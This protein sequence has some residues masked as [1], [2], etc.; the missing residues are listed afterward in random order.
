MTLE[1]TCGE[2]ADTKAINASYLIMD[3]LSPYSIILGQPTIN[4]IRTIISTQYLGLKYM[5]PGGK[6][7]MIRGDQ[8]ITQECYKNSL[9]TKR[10]ELTLVGA[11]SMKSQI[12]TSIF[13][14]PGRV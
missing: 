5:I 6:V 1:I 7:G 11:P 13:G 3:V 9:A 14:I 2:G 4:A 10:E 12:R 8:Q